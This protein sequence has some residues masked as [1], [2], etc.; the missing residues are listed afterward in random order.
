MNIRKYML[1]QGLGAY[2]V[3]VFPILIISLTLILVGIIGL[4]ADQL[5][6]NIG[7]IQLQ[8]LWSGIAGAALHSLLG[9]IVTQR[10][11]HQSSGHVN[12]HTPELEPTLVNV[13]SNEKIQTIIDIAQDAYIAVDRT[14]HVTDW[15]SQAEKMFGWRKHEVVDLTLSTLILPERFRDTYQEAIGNYNGTGRIDF[16]NRRME[17]IVVNRQ[18]EEFPIEVTIGLVNT[19]DSYFFSAFVH[20]ISER[21]KIERMKNEFISTVSHELRTPL[22]AIRASLSMLAA[23][24]AAEL[25]HDTRVLLDI[26]HNSCERLV[27]LV[28]DMLDIEKI[29]SGNIEF[30]MVEQPLQQLIELA[31]DAIEGYASQYQVTIMT[32]GDAGVRVKVDRDRMIQVI[33][34]LLSNA[35]KFSPSGAT[36]KL[37]VTREGEHVRLSVVDYGCGIPDAFRDRIF[38]KFAQADSTDSRQRGGTGLGLN[39]CKS[40][41]EEHNGTISFDSEEG[42]GAIFYVD[43]PAAEDNGG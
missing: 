7:H 2:L 41:V 37:Q 35:I 9:L 20:D 14:G 39:I 15:N 16:L 1:D 40:I 29:E 13:R 31:I 36:V 19:D 8:V 17:H 4:T 27:R 34:N 25:P 43:L 32:E 18:G 23:D 12:K 26:A 22:T 30:D 28:N 38:Q 21:K 33:T 11:A 6:P 42:K 24:M 10:I 5:K 3:F